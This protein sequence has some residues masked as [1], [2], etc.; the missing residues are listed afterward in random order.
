MTEWNA[1]AD[2]MLQI[3]SS[4]VP[5]RSDL[6]LRRV[7]AEDFPQDCAN[8]PIEG[9]WGYTQP[10]AIVFLREQFPPGMPP[11]FVQLEYHIAQKIVYE[12][13]IIFR[14]EDYRFSGIDMKLTKQNLA[15]VGG[16][17]YD[18]LEFSVT[19]WSDWHWN[20]LKK[21]WEDSDFGK[22]PNFD[23]EQHLFKR[24]GSQVTYE[25]MLWFDISD[26]FDLR[27]GSLH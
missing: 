25:R 13:L 17:Q 4:I 7:L 21:E 6:P 20:M 5:I 24:N 1:S 22:S 11:D 3:S 23:R 26:V 19:C 2:M 14:P 18:H 27:N 8:L 15:G 9:G 16:K 12:E 10:E